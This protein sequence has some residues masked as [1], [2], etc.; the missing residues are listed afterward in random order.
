MTEEE[1]M[2]QSRILEWNQKDNVALSLICQEDQEW[3][4]MLQNPEI[5]KQFIMTKRM[6]NGGMKEYGEI[7]V[8]GSIR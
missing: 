4:E 6:E 3:T 8:S 1:G 2:E 5:M 7:N